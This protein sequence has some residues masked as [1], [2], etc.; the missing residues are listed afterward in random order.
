MSIIEQLEEQL[1]DQLELVVEV[2]PAVDI[3]EKIKNG[4]LSTEELDNKQ[5]FHEVRPNNF[6][7]NHDTRIQVRGQDVDHEFIDRQITKNTPHLLKKKVVIFFPSDVF[8]VDDTLFA[9]GGDIKIV[10]GNHTA[11]IEIGLGILKSQSYIINFDTQLGGS[12]YEA[13]DLGN[14]LNVCEEERRGTKKDDVRNLVIQ[15][16]DENEVKN[17]D[18]NDLTDTEK[19][20]LTD[21]QIDRLVNSYKFITTY[22]IGQWGSYH[23]TSGGR[24]KCKITYTD[25]E[26]S[27]KW[28]H[29][30]DQEQYK[31]YIIIEPRSLESWKQTAVSTAITEHLSDKNINSKGEI[32]KNKILFIFHCSSQKQADNKETTKVLMKKHYDRMKKCYGMEIKSEFLRHE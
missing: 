27:E 29:Y 5:F 20:K 3:V 1:D 9:R 8:D 2:P 10:G 11:S 26:L 25:V 24:R 31:D 18:R 32:I 15:L 4:E 13:L 21:E 22:T 16:M 19:A 12:I 7:I 30:A 28:K 14:L 23:E 17:K 6:A